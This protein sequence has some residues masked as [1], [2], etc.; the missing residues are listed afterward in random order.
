MAFERRGTVFRIRSREDHNK[1]GTGFVVHVDKSVPEDRTA[2]LLTCAHVIHDLGE[3]SILV[4]DMSAEVIAVGDKDGL[5]L[6][7]LKVK[8]LKDY[9][10]D[11]LLLSTVATSTG[12]LNDP[13]GVCGFLGEKRVPLQATLNKD[14]DLPKAKELRFYQLVLN[15]DEAVEPDQ[16]KE[17]YSGS[18]IVLSAKE[19]KVYAVLNTRRTSKTEKHRV[20]ACIPVW[21]VV[22]IWPEMPDHLG[23]QL[24]GVDYWPVLKQV[25][26]Q[27]ETLTP[28]NYETAFRSACENPDE[29]PA[30]H[31][32][33]GC[34]VSL[35]K[36]EKDG[37]STARLRCF[38]K[39]LGIPGYGENPSID[40]RTPGQI[41]DETKPSTQK[42]VSPCSVYRQLIIRIV[43]GTTSRRSDVGGRGGDRYWTEAHTFE[44]EACLNF[45]CDQGDKNCVPN[46]I[47][48]IKTTYAR[49]TGDERPSCLRELLQEEIE[50]IIAVFGRY[51]PDLIQIIV[52]DEMLFDLIVTDQMDRVLV[53]Q[54]QKPLADWQPTIF[55]G[56]Q[57]SDPEGEG[58]NLLSRLDN[59]NSPLQGKTIDRY[60][61]DWDKDQL[62]DELEESIV[63]ILTTPEDVRRLLKIASFNS[64]EVM[65]P[66]FVPYVLVSTE[67][68]DA[69]LK[70]L[71]TLCCFR[72]IAYELR[73]D[74]S[75]PKRL[76]I[77]ANTPN[78][79][80]RFAGT[81][82]P[83]IVGN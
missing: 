44:Q 78:I 23:A 27:T 70:K 43:K 1:Y 61:S 8:F 65:A 3:G 14:E 2:Y 50:D 57:M 5:D 49:R 42:V 15:P 38:L 30:E 6:A 33:W 22:K 35:L 75:L 26:I 55:S 29:F 4:D 39:E 25:R 80:I 66:F 12:E 76:S 18:P 81:E 83:I 16:L 28:N 40:E 79:N 62:L 24:F 68:A 17:G 63:A 46:L 19:E 48:E 56:E 58:R 11:N 21:H 45:C 41:L 73:H 10:K 54:G 34:A 82:E 59:A 13:V 47:K 69:V 37:E 77:I 20:G 7:V 52:P 64:P 9:L 31:S 60:N 72:R 74:K 51:V 71:Q 67:K 36:F 32:L 53:R